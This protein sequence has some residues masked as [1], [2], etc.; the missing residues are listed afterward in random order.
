MSEEPISVA[1][2]SH[3]PVRRNRLHEA[4]TG[5]RRLASAWAAVNL[6]LI[7][8]LLVGE[9]SGQHLP[10]AREWLGLALWP[11]GV[12]IGLVICWFRARVGGWV[13]LG[14]LVGFYLWNLAMVGQFPRGPYFILFAAPGA[15]Y[16][17]AEWM[18]RRAA[19]T[20]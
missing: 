17:L 13:T 4:A 20:A 18:Y 15:L 8:I 12:G 2:D 5:V 19:R 16:L 11:I 7:V 10:S 1:A 6:L 3:N 9:L 14:S